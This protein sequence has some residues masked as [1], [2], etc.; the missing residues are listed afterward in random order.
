[1]IAGMSTP[2]N[3][4]ARKGGMIRKRRQA[5][6]WDQRGLADRVGVHVNSVQRWESGKQYPGRHLGKVEAVL[7]ITIDDEPEP[8][9]KI[10]KGLYEVILNTDGLTPEERQAVI[11]AVE[12]TLAT[13]RGGAPPAAPSV[14]PERE[15]PASLSAALPAPVRL[16]PALARLSSASVPTRAPR[17]GSSRLRPQR[18]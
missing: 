8:Q 2:S 11:D 1:M 10:P 9:P 7:G 16:F 3:W 5:L 18:G 6:G 12:R 14:R 17:R 4:D 15:R 13:E